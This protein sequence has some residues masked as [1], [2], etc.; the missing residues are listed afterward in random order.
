KS[1]T[2]QLFPPT[3]QPAQH[4]YVASQLAELDDMLSTLPRSTRGAYVDA[5]MLQQRTSAPAHAVA[6]NLGISPHTQ[7]SARDFARRNRSTVHSLH[8]EGSGMHY[9]GAR[10][11]DSSFG[12]QPQRRLA[13]TR[14]NS[15]AMLRKQREMERAALRQ[16]KAPLAWEKMAASSSGRRAF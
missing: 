12:E 3:P 8:A 15:D 7:T 9:A 6:M 2:M 1:R 5:L 14:E 11:L 16:A 13:V 4:R 10:A